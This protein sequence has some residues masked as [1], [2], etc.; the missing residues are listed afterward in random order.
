[1]PGLKY[2]IFSVALQGCETWSLTL[3]EEGVLEQNV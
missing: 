2:I 1:M 3:M